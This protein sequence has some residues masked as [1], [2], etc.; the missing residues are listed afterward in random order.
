VQVA[1]LAAVE[2]DGDRAKALW[3]RVHPRPLTRFGEDLPARGEP[4]PGGSGVPSHA[5]APS[6]FVVLTV[7]VN[8]ARNVTS[9]VPEWERGRGSSHISHRRG[10]RSLDERAAPPAL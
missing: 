6:R 3:A 8:G 9:S 7:D 10:V 4:C 2:A 5:V 1:E